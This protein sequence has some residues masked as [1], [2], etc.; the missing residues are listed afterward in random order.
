MGK[1]LRIAM[2]SKK[3]AKKTNLTDLFRNSANPPR[4]S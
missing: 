2:H 1:V 3:A 4:I